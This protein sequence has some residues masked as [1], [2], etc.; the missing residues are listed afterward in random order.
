MGKLYSYPDINSEG[1]A[2]I[3][4]SVYFYFNSLL[5]FRVFYCVNSTKVSLI[6][7]IK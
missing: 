7:I 5:T 4:F 2:S 3:S 6:A 1:I